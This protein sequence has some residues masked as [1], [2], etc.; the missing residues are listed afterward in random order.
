MLQRYLPDAKAKAFYDTNKVFFD[1]VYVR[2]SHILIQLPPTATKEQRDKA[3]NQLLV[4]RQDIVTGKAKFE[5]VAKQH[6]DCVSKSQGGDIGKFEYLFIVA[7]EFSKAAF[8][9]KVG[10]I[11]NVVQTVYGV[12]LIKVTERTP[13]EPSNFEAIKDFVREAWAEDEKLYTRFLADQRKKSDVMD[14]SGQE[15]AKIWIPP[16]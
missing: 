15:R 8:A 14:W 16:K 11:S 1:K 5:D 6:S 10:E 13:G 4:W 2:A 9:M 3:V 12:H 7:P